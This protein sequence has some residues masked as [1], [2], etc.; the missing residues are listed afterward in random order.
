MKGRRQE[1]EASSDYWDDAPIV[2]KEDVEGAYCD[3][4]EE[5]E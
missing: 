4:G 5:E 2:T 1:E 3:L